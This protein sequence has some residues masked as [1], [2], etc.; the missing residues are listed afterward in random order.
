M[1]LVGWVDSTRGT[2]TAQGGLL[3]GEQGGNAVFVVPAQEDVAERVLYRQVR[4]VE[5]GWQRQLEAH[6]PQYPLGTFLM[7]TLSAGRNKYPV[8]WALA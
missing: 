6:V 8:S 2:P 5:G 7:P 3:Q 4:F 1:M